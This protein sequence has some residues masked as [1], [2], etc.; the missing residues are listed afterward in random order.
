M[1]EL[2]PISNAQL[3]SICRL[4]A[5]A[6]TH[7]QLDLLFLDAGIDETGGSPRWERMLLALQ[8]R[9]AEDG[10][11]N[12]VL[13]FMA[14]VLGPH[15]GQ[16]Q[17]PQLREIREAVNVQLA[18][19][20]VQV[21]EDG[22]VRR[23]ARAETLSAAEMLA[24]ELRQELHRRSVHEDVL[25][26]CRAELLDRNFF[27]CV[28]EASKSLAEKIRERTGLTEDGADLVA[29]AFRVSD[30]LL[31]LNTLRSETEKSE[32]KGYANLLTGIFGTFRNVPAHA[33][34]LK[35]A[36]DRREALDALTIISYAHRRLD[37][38]VLVRRHSSPR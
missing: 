32:Q 7:R 20:G 22:G 24:A 29:A 4:L 6:V 8:K 11:G 21:G 16:G 9:Q 38:A 25:R 2:P 33:P 14:R 34:R 26:Y 19:L 15:R 35:W 37:E 13:A 12:N 28:L 23:S 1:P 27:H 18:F 31:A 17:E 10:C 36:I 30:P 3:D 5:D